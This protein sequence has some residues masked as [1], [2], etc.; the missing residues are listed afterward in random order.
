[1]SMISHDTFFVFAFG[2]FAK[3]KVKMLADAAFLTVGST[4]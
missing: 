2:F 4:T 1:M 3:Y